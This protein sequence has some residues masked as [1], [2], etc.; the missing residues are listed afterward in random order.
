MISIVLDI[1]VSTFLFLN[2]CE[3]IRIKNL[4]YKNK[5]I[6]RKY[7]NNMWKK[8]FLKVKNSLLKLEKDFVEL[9]DRELKDRD[10]KI[11]IEKEELSLNRSLCLKMIWIGLKKKRTEE[12]KTN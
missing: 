12:N 7:L 9:K 11:K 3:Y 10:V 4:N 6:E 1:F 8:Q 5:N 2:F